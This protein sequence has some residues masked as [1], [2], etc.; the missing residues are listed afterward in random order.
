[1]SARHCPFSVPQVSGA[2]VLLLAQL[3]C[4]PQYELLRTVEEGGA[5]GN[6]GG[7]QPGGTSAGGVGLGGTPSGGG[8]DWGDTDSGGADS[9][10]ADSGGTDSGTSGGYAS[11]GTGYVGGGGNGGCPVAPANCAGPCQHGL[12][13]R[14]M[15]RSGCA[16]CECVPPS[17]CSSSAD[18]QNDEACYAGA[19]CEDG[20]SD[21]ACCFG[22]R[23]SKP[24]CGVSRP[25][26]CLAFG[27]SD[28]ELCQAAC[29]ATSCE[30]DGADWTCENTT[31]GAPVASCPQACVPP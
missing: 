28:G 4:S 1:M 30:C 8:R 31:G 3:G 6:L 5:G 13:P 9:G 2:L 16:V 11:G 25:P 27:C 24:G 29:D 15:S 12:Q 26:F 20:C 21:P 22:N 10:G 18:C 14:L 7:A 19:Q 23:C 17:E